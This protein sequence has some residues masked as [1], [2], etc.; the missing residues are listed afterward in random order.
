MSRLFLTCSLDSFY[1]VCFDSSQWFASMSIPKAL[2][3]YV[4]GEWVSNWWADVAVWEEK[5]RKNTPALV[6][7]DGPIQRGRRWFKQFYSD[8]SAAAS[9]PQ[10]FDW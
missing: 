8:G 6:K 5:I 2:A 1:F 4:V 10:S 9:K 3:S 7:G